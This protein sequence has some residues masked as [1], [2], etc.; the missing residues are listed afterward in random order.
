MDKSFHAQF[1]R[2]LIPISSFAK[3]NIKDGYDIVPMLSDTWKK[4]EFRLL[5]VLETVDWTDIKAGQLL[6]TEVD[7]KRGHLLNPLHNILPEVLERAWRSVCSYRS[8]SND[9][10]EESDF[11][12]GVI[13]FN[14]VKTKV[15]ETSQQ[16][17]Y[18]R[19]FAHRVA[20]FIKQKSPTHV[21]MCG[22]T[23]HSLTLS[24]LGVEIPPHEFI[25]NG[26]VRNVDV[27]EE[28]IKFCQTLD[29]EP[30]YNPNTKKDSITEDEADLADKFA[31]ADL[32][33]F[34]SRCTANLL[35]GRMMYT[36]GKLVPNPV[37]VDTIEKFDELYSRLLEESVIALDTEDRNLTGYNNS[38]YVVQVAFSKKE[39]YVIPI[40]HPKT[41]HEQEIADYIRD[42]LV[43]FLSGKAT[44]PELKE[45]VTMNGSFDLK[46]LRAQWDIKFIPH[47]IYEVTAGEVVLDENIGILSRTASKLHVDGEY[48]LCSYNGLANLLTLYGSDFYHT[49]Q[50]SKAERGNIGSMP[51]DD[52]EVLNYEA[53][54]V[55]CLIAIR[56]A[57]LK[58]AANTYI[59][60]S[61]TSKGLV[62][63][64]NM[65]YRLVT[66]QMSN[67]VVSISYMEQY[68]SH[69]DLDYL[70]GLAEPGSPLRVEIKKAA[71][72]LRATEAV[73]KVNDLLN[74]SVGRKSA[75]LFGGALTQNV[76]SIRKKAHLERLFFDV[77]GLEYLRFTKTGERAIDKAFLENYV[78][79]HEEV[80]L[81]SAYNKAFKLMSTYV[82]GW[83]KKVKENLDSAMDNCLRA[84]FVFFTIVT[85]RLGSKNPNLQQI[86]SRGPNAKILKRAFT[87]PEGMLNIQFDY[88]A[89]EVR[90][91]GIAAN[92]E[93]VCAA[94]RAGQ[95]LRKQW[96][97]TPTEEIAKDLKTKGDVHIA[98]VYRFFKKWVTKDSPERYSI[99]AVVFGVIYGKSA[100]TL[101]NDMRKDKISE[102]DNQIRAVNVEI[103]QLEAS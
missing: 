67:T 90:C 57:Q 101:G 22:A 23:A 12:V 89:H 97:A 88:S 95:D 42:K 78:H 103:K 91:W 54:D 53:M 87:A 75:G 98:N 38:V 16:R 19:K 39:G 7:S 60:P 82:V 63:Y 21:L 102:I 72:A 55:Q 83:N 8:N 47:R 2:Q 100:K 68:G 43:D 3:Y 20:E 79:D 94:F 40:Y 74:E 58:R 17:T 5:I 46:V 99:K 52:P 44:G 56:A 86:P 26:W 84:G 25:K 64:Q 6:S 13:N 34:V 11:A 1:E 14:A 32:L 69:L 70:K 73:K 59:R 50:F 48:K 80:K 65:F 29:L 27:N 36:V 49:A 61:F 10:Y 41:P 77:L 93:G 92:D 18:H 85:G 81:F 33:Y 96:I 28:N 31:S 35:Y 76:F 45:I 15:L 30:L 62:S 37:Y 66:R 24:A 4:S 9:A 71:D 51:P